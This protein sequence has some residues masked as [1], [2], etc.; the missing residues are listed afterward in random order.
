MLRFCLDNLVFLHKLQVRYCY[1][2]WHCTVRSAVIEEWQCLG[3]NKKDLRLP[4]GVRKIIKKV[5]LAIYLFAFSSSVSWLSADCVLLSF[6]TSVPSFNKVGVSVSYCCVTNL[7]KWSALNN[8]YLWLLMS[9]QASWGILLIWAR[10][11]W[12]QLGLVISLQWPE[13]YGL[14]RMASCGSSMDVGQVDRGDSAMFLSLFSSLAWVC[15]QDRGRILRDWMEVGKA[16][17]DLGLVLLLCYFCCDDHLTR[18]LSY[19]QQKLIQTSSD[20]GEF[21]GRVSGAC[22]IDGG[23]KG[24]LG[25]V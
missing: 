3:R 9:V 21:A 16:S 6:E 1:Y 2:G 8:K 10:L 12:F 14:P 25:K 20:E 13:G 15:S 4:K 18:V 22:T 17:W 23:L 5:T 7:P 11:G 24:W 19:R